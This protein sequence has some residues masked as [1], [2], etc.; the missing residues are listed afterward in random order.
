MSPTKRSKL[1]PDHQAI[2]DQFDRLSNDQ[3]VPDPVSAAVLGISTWTLNRTNPVRK[4][5][6]S[7]RRGGRRVGDLRAL[8]RGETVAA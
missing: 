8:V 5:Q 7:Q 2:F 4:R 6:I 3:V 1:S